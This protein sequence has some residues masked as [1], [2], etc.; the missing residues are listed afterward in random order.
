MRA[1]LA[2]ALASACLVPGVLEQ[3]VIEIGVTNRIR[4]GTNAFTGRD[5]SCYIMITIKCP[6]G[7]KPAG[8]KT[9]APGRTCTECL[10]TAT[11]RVYETR[12]VAAEA[13]G[14]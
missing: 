4:T 1:L 8:E 7:P 3:R 10:R 14:R 5:A 9:G 11:I 13:Q 2:E 12:P 6:A